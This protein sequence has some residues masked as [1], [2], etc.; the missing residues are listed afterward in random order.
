MD[1]LTLLSDRTAWIEARIASKILRGRA[2]LMSIYSVKILNFR[3]IRATG[4]VRLESIQDSF[5]KPILDVA[6][7]MPRWHP[8]PELTAFGEALVKALAPLCDWGNENR[9][10]V[11]ELQQSLPREAHG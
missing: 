3:I 4:C 6:T 1:E 7:S 9:K 5:R 8:P 10:A 2:R 11:I